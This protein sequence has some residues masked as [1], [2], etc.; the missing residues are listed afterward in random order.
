MQINNDPNISNPNFCQL[1]MQS[2]KKSNK[3]VG[4]YIATEL[5]K[6]RP[7]IKDLANDC[8]IFLLPKDTSD[9]LFA[10]YEIIVAEPSKNLIQR[11]TTILNSKY[12]SENVRFIDKPMFIKSVGKEPDDK[13]S[14][15][16]ITIGTINELKSLWIG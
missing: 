11:I 14:I 12:V 8:D 7:Q 5:E 4:Q 13:K 3:K 2:E 16:D 10:F 6:I 1:F 9:K 15:A